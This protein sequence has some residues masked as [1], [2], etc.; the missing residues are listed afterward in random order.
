[1]SCGPGRTSPPEPA[2]ASGPGEQ[3]WLTPGVWSVGAASLG[4]DADHELTTILL[5]TFLTS[6]LHAGPAALGAI[7]GVSEALVMRMPPT[8]PA[9]C[10]APRNPCT[11]GRPTT[12]SGA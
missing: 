5:P 7:E 2:Q 8:A 3:P 6:T 10:K 12:L 1:M 9:W 11:A 4:S